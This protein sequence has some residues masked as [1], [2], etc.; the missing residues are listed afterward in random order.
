MALVVKNWPANAGDQRDM[1]LIP[2]YERSSR[3]GH[4]NPLQALPGGLQ[5]REAWR[6]TVKGHR[7]SDTTEVT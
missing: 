2:G 5:N 3:E 4:G 6:A 1:G 7:E